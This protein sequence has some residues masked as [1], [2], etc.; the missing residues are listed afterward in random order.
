MTYHSFCEHCK[1]L[2]PNKH[3]DCVDNQ[4]AE[5]Y[6][7]GKQEGANLALAIKDGSCD[8]RIML[9]LAKQ[10]EELDNNK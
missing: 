4:K 3:F 2:V 7:Q 6:E 10:K 5:S 8:Q 1:S 9:A